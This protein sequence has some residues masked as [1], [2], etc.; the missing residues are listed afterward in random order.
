MGPQAALISNGPGFGSNLQTASAW[1]MQ[2]RQRA[3]A[4][5]PRFW[6]WRSMADNE[7]RH[8]SSMGGPWGTPTP[9][10]LIQGSKA[11]KRNLVH[12]AGTR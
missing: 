8:V 2:N 5:L 10:A 12:H 1:A 4:L 11:C 7:G 3:P 9:Q 6:A